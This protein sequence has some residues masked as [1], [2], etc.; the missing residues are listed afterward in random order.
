MGQLVPYRAEHYRAATRGGLSPLVGLVSDES[1]D[2]YA[3]R[4]VGYTG[5]V[6]DAIAGCAG[7]VTYW[8]GVGEAWAVLTDVGRAHPLFVHRSVSRGLREIVAS[9]RLRRVQADVVADFAIGRRW[10]ECLGFEFE[11]LMRRYGPN[12]ED[13]ARYRVLP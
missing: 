8:P 13:F 1:A 11:S 10:V 7:V 3:S 6:G 12:G 2:Y 9:S 5:F 4:G